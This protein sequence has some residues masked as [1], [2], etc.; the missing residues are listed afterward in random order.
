L[1]VLVEEGFGREVAEGAM[2][3]AAIVEGLE[4]VEEGG[5]SGLAGWEGL[6]LW[7]NLVLVLPVL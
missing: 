2:K 3:A 7:E 4:V 6:V 5:R 1:E